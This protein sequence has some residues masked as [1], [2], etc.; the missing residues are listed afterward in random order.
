VV[1]EL[2]PCEAGEV[3]RSRDGGELRLRSCETPFRESGSPPSSRR[4]APIHFPRFAGEELRQRCACL[5][6]DTISPSDQRCCPGCSCHL[7]SWEERGACSHAVGR[8]RCCIAAAIAR[9]HAPRGLTV[10]PG[11]AIGVAGSTHQ[12]GSPRGLSSIAS[13]RFSVSGPVRQAP[14]PPI[15]L[16]RQCPCGSFH[17]ANREG[18]HTPSP[19]RDDLLAGALSRPPHLMRHASQRP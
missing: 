8:A 3:R 5:L 17:R 9:L 12:G 10:C 15:S 16:R 7:P 2:F 14:D 18:S 19:R 11:V 13:D 1:V 4:C 6:P